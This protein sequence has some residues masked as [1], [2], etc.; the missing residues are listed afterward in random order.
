MTL[1]LWQHLF[2]NHTGFLC[3]VHRPDQRVM[4]HEYFVWPD[5][6]ERA[7]ARAA[8]L[9]QAADVFFCVRLLVEPRRLATTPGRATALWCDLDQ[10]L[11]L[12]DWPEAVPWPTAIVESGRGWHCYWRL[13]EPVDPDE[14][15]AL[16]RA[17]AEKLGGD[18]AAAD[19]ARLLRVPG[20]LNHKYQPP[21]PVRLRELLDGEAYSPD[22]FRALAARTSG[23]AREPVSRLVQR[24]LNEGERNLSLTRIAGALRGFGLDESE[25]YA[26][27]STLNERH[28][29]PPLPDA[30][31][32]AIVRS[33]ARWQ[34]NPRIAAN[35]HAGPDAPATVPASWDPI[36]ASALARSA[37]PD[38]PWVWRGVL[39]RG[40]L[41]LLSGH[42]KVGKTTLLVQLLE[43]LADG[44]ALAGQ[45]VA[46]GRALVITEEACTLWA[47]RAREHRLD[48]VDVLCR[49]FAGRPS[50][51]EWA[52]LC[53]HVDALVR[54]R[55]YSLVVF[56]TI[57]ALWSC[58]DENDAAATLRALVPLQAIAEAGAAVLCVH[59][60]RKSDGAEG[61]ASRGSSAIAGFFDFVVELR[62]FKGE[63]DQRRQLSVLS[64]YEPLEVV[65]DRDGGLLGDPASVATRDV[66]QAVLAALREAGESGAT[67]DELAET[68][69]LPST[70]LRRVLRRLAEAGS[71]GCTGAGHRNSPRRWYATENR[72]PDYYHH[73]IGV[74]NGGNKSGLGNH[75]AS[76]YCHHIATTGDGGG[77]KPG[78]GQRASDYCHHTTPL[79]GGN[80]PDSGASAAGRPLRELAACVLAELR[81]AGQPVP[82]TALAHQFDVPRARIVAA[83]GLLV[84]RGHATWGDPGAPSAAVH[85][86]L[87][88]RQPAPTPC[89]QVNDGAM[90][91]DTPAPAG[92]RAGGGASYALARA[93]QTVAQPE[94]GG[95]GLLAVGDVPG[96]RGDDPVRFLGSHRAEACLGIERAHRERYRCAL[97][98]E[99]AA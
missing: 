41:T 26:T 55:G 91:P 72:T 68:T 2:A 21:R 45:P 22:V 7:A 1:E 62:R 76:D 49:P 53:Q 86:T 90:R 67:A 58:A 98:Q 12:L 16:S 89:G 28:C 93:E 60:L 69:G 56:D 95:S 44:G 20:T 47:K 18:L 50:E 94:G 35:G 85:Q 75:P 51:P 79:G 19:A 59:H 81:A 14:A 71:V 29:S 36:P 88:Y 74:G 64:R 5:D 39:A 57:A 97:Q 10:P 32:R 87:V 99:G 24:T 25:L 61:T 80:K 84:G 3:V 46:P 40:H 73:H 27:L 70:T 13:S 42:P 6:A 43:Q 11:D 52:R 15:A 96:P 54:E 66:D 48:Q 92:S 78:A 8:E 23:H 38:V 82:L 31:V 83:A 37:E 33:A 30:E 34:P 65:V 63:H 9:G 17:L 77:N 4:R